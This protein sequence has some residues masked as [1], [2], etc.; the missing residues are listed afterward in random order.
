[1]IEIGTWH[2]K[3]LIYHHCGGKSPGLRLAVPNHCYAHSLRIVI[4]MARAFLWLAGLGEPLVLIG[5]P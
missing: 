4:R 3:G 5:F 2:T 1:M